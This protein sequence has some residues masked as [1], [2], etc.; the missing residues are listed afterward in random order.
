MIHER[1]TSLLVMPKHISSS[2]SSSSSIKLSLI[3]DLAENP[4][5][6]FQAVLNN[7]LTRY[8]EG[9]S[10]VFLIFRRV[11]KILKSDY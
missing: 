8:L 11:H 5:E 6:P 4:V 2:S 7:F 9:H 1:S 10:F 3:E